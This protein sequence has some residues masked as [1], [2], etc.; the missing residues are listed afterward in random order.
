MPYVWSMPFPLDLARPPTLR[1]VHHSEMRPG[2]HRWDNPRHWV[3]VGFLGEISLNA[4]PL[5]AGTFALWAP[6]GQRSYTVVRTCPLV[7]AVFNA[8]GAGTWCRSLG[9]Q[10]DA[11]HAALHRM[12]TWWPNRPARA[13]AGLW[14]L[15]WQLADLDAEPPWPVALELAR[16]HL[17][18]HLDAPLTVGDLARVAGCSDSHLLRLVRRHCQRD[19]RGWVRQR[20]IARARHLIDGG[21]SPGQAAEAVGIPDAHAFNKAFRREAGIAPSR[22]RGGALIAS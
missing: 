6:G 8:T 19:V 5:P 18:R 21:A 9:L 12:T 22:Y 11:L 16:A 1:S 13:Q 17:D 10:A 15:L 20:R 3:L 14:D 2:P 7:C 4:R